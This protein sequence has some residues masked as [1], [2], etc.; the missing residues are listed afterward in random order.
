MISGPGTVTFDNAA[1]PRTAAH[2]ST[3]G[4]YVLRLTAN[5]GEFTVQ[6][7][8]TVTVAGGNAYAS[9]KAANF[10]ASELADP[11]I[12]GD[13]ADPDGDGFSNV[14]EFTAGTNPRDGKSYLSVGAISTDTGFALQFEAMPGRSYEIV[15][16][17]TVD[18]GIWS[19][20]QSVQSPQTEQSIQINLGVTTDEPTRF[21][22][23]SVTTP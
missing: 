4:S 7:E 16:R 17:E 11:N 12:S 19:I 5:D 8:M 14:A 15:T 21:Y 6:D 3:A 18:S 9:W 22:K 20:V 13:D 2:F 23:L 10:T 1:S